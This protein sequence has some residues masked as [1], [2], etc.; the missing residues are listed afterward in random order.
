MNTAGKLS[1]EHEQ[2]ENLMYNTTTRNILKMYLYLD[3]NNRHSRSTR[4]KQNKKPN[5]VNISPV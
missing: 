3:I 2:N 5:W 1:E 4:S